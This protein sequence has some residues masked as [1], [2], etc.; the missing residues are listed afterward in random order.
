MGELFDK[1]CS[2]PALMDAWK[3]I[4]TKK[5]AGGLDRVSVGDFE[6]D[7]A[8]NI[9][10]I[11]DDLKR[12]RYAPEPLERI[13][14]PK[15]DGSRE[16]RPLS[17][18]SVRDKIVQQAVR[19]LT[20]PLFQPIFLDC[21]YAYRPGR[22]PGKAYRRVNHYLT[23]EKR[24]WV[25]LA[26]FDRFFD[27][28]DQDILIREMSKVINDPDV[29]RLIRMWTKVG[30][31]DTGGRYF[32]I[33]AGVGQGSVIS[34]LLSNIYVHPLDEYM[35]QNGYAYVRYS[36][37]M[38]ILCRSRKDA[39]E[40]L[41][42]FKYFSTSALKLILNENPHPIK[43]LDNGFVF[44]GIYY[45]GGVRA[46][47]NAKMAKIKRKL[48]AITHPNAHP[49]FLLDKVNRS[50]AG[51]RNYYCI[52]EP[53][54]QMM[55]ID[56]Y[57]EERIAPLL[58]GYVRQDLYRNVRDLLGYLRPLEFASRAYNRKKEETLRELAGAALKLAIS[59]KEKKE[60]TQS[61]KAEIRKGVMSADKAISSRKRKFLRT[62]RM[63][64]EVVVSTHGAFLGK[65][66]KRIVISS[67][68]KT[69]LSN[70][71]DRTRNVIIANKGITISSDLIYECSNKK[72][73]IFFMEAY[74]PP[75]AMVH[76][77]SPPHASIGISQLEARR[78]GQGTRIAKS[79][80]IGKIKNQLNLMKFYGRSRKDDEQFQKTLD[81][82]ETEIDS[83]VAHAKEV[84]GNGVE[85]RVRDKL[86][87]IEGRA[88]SSYW[89]LVKMLL[90]DDVVFSGRVRKGASDLVNS[91]LNY[92]YGILYARVW[93]AVTLAGLNPYLSFLH[94][95]Q[96]NKPTLVFDMIE[97]FRSQAVDR[98]VF[99]M[100]TRGE[101]LDLNCKTGLLT[102]KSRKKVIENVLLRLASFVPYR[103]KKLQLAE[104]I[105]LQPRHLAV[106]MEEDKKYRPFVGRY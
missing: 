78:N 100:F 22:G 25:V 44:L 106:C 71:L 77:P 101:N 95:L 94:E 83:L 48:K 103:G 68:G 33:D 56:Q 8:R 40:A 20:E 49:D 43:S 21:S 66:G 1:V 75:Y 92:G 34:P 82:M 37:N 62:K 86:F 50:L 69:L 23:T 39:E 90:A 55:E 52:I 81:V 42:D 65:R 30:F 28:I 93:R 88:A 73:S 72:I 26:D 76:I 19:S 18:P 47:S 41:D 57:M 13:N 32:D 64:S 16:T 2:L 84:K 58:A 9:N 74:G 85:T 98:A 67:R 38:I 87:S 60:N 89:G 91:I 7:L 27:S 24:R 102:D 10:R 54:E 105:C 6:A 29:I 96:K 99:T 104:V 35:L 36:D 12:G 4:R 97:E 45:R 61:M 17:L 3:R 11:M 5:A 53:E 31:V 51:L 46:I 59:T 14:T 15:F 79:I 70:P 63:A 80:V